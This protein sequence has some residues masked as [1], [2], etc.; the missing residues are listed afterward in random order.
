MGI[1]TQTLGHRMLLKVGPLATSAALVMALGSTTASG[2]A[3]LRPAS[4]SAFCH[5]IFTINM[6]SPAMTNYKTYRAWAVAYL[7]TY[8]KLAAEA[9]NASVKR[10]LNRIVTIMKATTKFKSIKPFASYIASHRTQW[11]SDWLALT[12]AMG[13]CIASIGTATG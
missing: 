6:K 2:G 8:E 11:A 7:P 5:T 10:F 1:W 12:K 4:Q 3:T 9:P 13:V